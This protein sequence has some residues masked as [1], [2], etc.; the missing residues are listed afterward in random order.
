MVTREL[1]GLRFEVR[2]PLPANPFATGWE[3]YLLGQPIVIFFDK[4]AW[5]LQSPKQ[6]FDFPTLDAAAW[7]L[8]D[9][10]QKKALGAPMIE[11]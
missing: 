5:V 6:Q 11:R 2:A 4:D 3:Y 10:I 7:H 8:A 9:S 1:H